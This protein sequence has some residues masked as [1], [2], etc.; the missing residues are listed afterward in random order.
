MV[1]LHFHNCEKLG[2]FYLLITYLEPKMCLRWAAAI[3]SAFPFLPPSTSIARMKLQILGVGFGVPHLPLLEPFQQSCGDLQE[4]STPSQDAAAALQEHWAL[5]SSSVGKCTWKGRTE[6]GVQARKLLVTE[7]ND[8]GRRYSCLFSWQCFS[9]GNS[10]LS[11][12]C[13]WKISRV[14]KY[15]FRIQPLGR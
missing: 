10:F 1:G 8:R 2:G 3:I 15:F 6:V 14:S 11:P 9:P 4:L 5:L 7:K 12:T 13:G